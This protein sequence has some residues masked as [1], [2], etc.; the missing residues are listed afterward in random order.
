MPPAHPFCPGYDRPPYRA[1]VEGYPG[2]E[3]YPPA[4]FRTEWG[5]IFH[6]GRLDG[7]ARILVI[8]QDP[9]THEDVARRIL[10][11]E[12]GQRIQGFLDKLG[13]TTSYVFVNTFLYSVYGQSGGTKHVADPL[14]ATARHA[15]LDALAADNTFEAVVTLG[16]LADKAYL[17][18]QKLP[19]THAATWRYVTVLHPTYPDSASASGS[20]TFAD[21]MKRLCESWNHGLDVLTAAPGGLTPDVPRALVHYGDAITPA[22]HGVIPEGDLPPGLPS[23]MRGA[24]SWANRAGTTQDTKRA[25]LTVTIPT[26][27]LQPSPPP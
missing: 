16:T 6:R 9:A 19:G 3:A 2:A 1:L 12:A 25:N 11:G 13:I 23:W 15:W 10:V 20:I 24:L 21:A 18:W 5:P 8:G 14:I 7:T 26:G 17:A 22:E 27:V 4:A